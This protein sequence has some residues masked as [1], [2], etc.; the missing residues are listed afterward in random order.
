MDRPV[1][2]DQH[3]AA[4]AI[5]SSAR[6]MAW[7]FRPSPSPSADF[8]DVFV[9][10]VDVLGPAGAADTEMVHQRSVC[11]MVQPA[12]GRRAPVAVGRIVDLAHGVEARTRSGCFDAVRDVAYVLMSGSYILPFEA[13]EASLSVCDGKDR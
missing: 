11:A 9:R 6:T 12:L 7:R 2:G 3:D 13:P 8:L 10:V 5:V 4:F 1:R